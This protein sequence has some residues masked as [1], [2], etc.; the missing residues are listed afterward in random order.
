MVP[1][2]NAPEVT[3]H[4][5]LRHRLLL[6]PYRFEGVG[7]ICVADDASDLPVA[8]RPNPSGAVPKLRRASFPSPKDAEDCH[9][10][11]SAIDGPHD[12]RSICLPGSEPIEEKLAEA[13]EPDKGPVCADHGPDDL[14]IRMQHRCGT[15]RG[16]GP[17]GVVSD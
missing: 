16:C 4:V 7:W 13:V 15:L 6:Q 5:L 12:F 9:H 3:L 17:H 2:H 11:I 8:D 1:C 14:E 10:V